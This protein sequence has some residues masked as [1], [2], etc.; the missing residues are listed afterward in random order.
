L[1]EYHDLAIDTI[2]EGLEFLNGLTLNIDTQNREPISR[3]FYMIGIKRKSQ[4]EIYERAMHLALEQSKIA[5]NVP[6]TLDLL[7][8]LIEEDLKT[9][10]VLNAS[11]RL[12]EAIEKLEY[13]PVG[14]GKKFNT[15]LEDHIK[16]L[17]KKKKEKL[18]DIIT[19]KHQIIQQ[20]FIN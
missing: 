14:M 6:A 5:E 15:L 12:D 9:D 1:L 7:Y 8:E 18:I 13:A 20:K 3:I 10:N 17:K 16:K 19:A 2:M 4:K 11:R